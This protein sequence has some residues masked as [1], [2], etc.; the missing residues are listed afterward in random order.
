MLFIHEFVPLWKK[1]FAGIAGWRSPRRT[2]YKS[3]TNSARLVTFR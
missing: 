1:I 3:L 2:A